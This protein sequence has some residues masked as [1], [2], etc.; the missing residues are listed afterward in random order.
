VFSVKPPE[1]DW[2]VG[3]RAFW[4]DQLA[5]I[6]DLIASGGAPPE[7]LADRRAEMQFALDNAGALE[8]WEKEHYAQFADAAWRG[9]RSREPM[10]VA[11]QRAY[12]RWLDGAVRDGK[13][14]TRSPI[15]KARLRGWLDRQ[16]AGDLVGD[17]FS[18][19]RMAGRSPRPRERRPRRTPSASRDGPE[20]PDD[21]EDPLDRAR[22][23][24][25]L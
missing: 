25:S 14:S 18:R 1:P 2:R 4:D 21:P 12:V 3:L 19:A 10:P 23:R 24:W 11:V 22:R 17:L 16:H 5:L 15:W 7:A 13:I 8:D 6:R 20:P 9:Q